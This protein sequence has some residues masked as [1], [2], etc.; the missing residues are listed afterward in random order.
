MSNYWLKNISSE[1]SQLK[2]NLNSAPELELR[3]AAR[4]L[5]KLEMEIQAC[6]SLLEARLF[7]AEIDNMEKELQAT[8]V[9]P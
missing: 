1:L 2:T 3:I 7:Q 4:T 5:A 9:K 6:R 8:K